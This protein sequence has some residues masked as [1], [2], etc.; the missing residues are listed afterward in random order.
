MTQDNQKI[1]NW[2]DGEK[3]KDKNDLEIEKRKFIEQIRKNKKE[4]LFQIPK[5]NTLWQKI[6]I[7]ILGR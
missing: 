3:T 5:K 2:L 1:L 4:D 6:R 7:M